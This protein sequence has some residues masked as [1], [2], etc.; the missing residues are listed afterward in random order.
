MK[1][2]GLSTVKGVFCENENGVMPEETN[3]NGCISDFLHGLRQQRAFSCTAG[4]QQ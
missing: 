3:M 1:M 2:T 4:A